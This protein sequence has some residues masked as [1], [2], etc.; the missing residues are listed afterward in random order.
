MGFFRRHNNLSAVITIIIVVIASSLAAVPDEQGRHRPTNSK[1]TTYLTK[2]LQAD[3][4][5]DYAAAM[6][7]RISAG[8]TPENNAAVLFWQAVGPN[9]IPKWSRQRFFQQVGI[10]QP[11]ETGEYFVELSAYPRW[12]ES[13]L[14]STRPGRKP[15]YDTRAD[16]SPVLSRP[17]SKQEFPIIAAWLAA[18]EKPLGL[19]TQASRRPRRYD[20]LIVQDDGVIYY[21]ITTSANRSVFSALVARAM[22]RTQEGRVDDAWQ[23]LLACHRLARLTS[24]CQITRPYAWMTAYLEVLA[25][26]GDHVLLKNARLTARQIAAMRNDLARLPPKPSMLAKV[27]FGDRCWCLNDV[28]LNARHDSSSPQP[29]ANLRITPT[30]TIEAGVNWNMV[31]RIV[32]FWFD[33]RTAAMHEPSPAKQWAAERRIRDDLHDEVVASVSWTAKLSAFFNP[34]EVNSKQV[35]LTFVD[36]HLVMLTKSEDGLEIQR[37]LNE[38]AFALAAYRIDHGSYPARLNDLRPAYLKE[39]PKNVFAGDADLHYSRK[40]D[41]YLLYSVGENGKDDGGRGHWDTKKYQD[42]DDLAVRMSGGKP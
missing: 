12:R 1:E 41:G 23:D 25:I 7:E 37:N 27:D 11:P 34:R 39:V 18:N 40:G 22:L 38:V 8:V 32:N 14:K 30:V 17:W 19:L 13:K 3:G 28:L 26:E 35:A 2:P 20:P 16:L 15:S 10:P 5:P 6:N 21:G 42:Y 9:A 31:L 4:Y 29:F 24:R 36:S 33:R